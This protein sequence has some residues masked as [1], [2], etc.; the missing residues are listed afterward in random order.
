M[1]SGDESHLTS[2]SVQ[3][4]E[5]AFCECVFTFTTGESGGKCKGCQILAYCSNECQREHW[6]IHKRRCSKSKKCANCKTRYFNVRGS[7]GGRCNTCKSVYY[8][9][10]S[11]QTEHWPIH[12]HLCGR[13]VAPVHPTA[14]IPNLEEDLEEVDWRSCYS[15]CEVRTKL[16]YSMWGETTLSLRSTSPGFIPRWLLYYVDIL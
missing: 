12:Q 2:I 11:C 13:R 8:C 14:G 5:C 6:A 7:G 15:R 3:R 10:R 4:L 1:S 16:A 9:S